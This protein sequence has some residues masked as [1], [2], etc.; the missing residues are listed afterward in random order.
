MNVKIFIYYLAFGENKPAWNFRIIG[1][2][3]VYNQLPPKDGTISYSALVIKSL[4]WPG[5]ITVFKV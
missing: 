4:R 1:D 3:Q 2:T 5:Y